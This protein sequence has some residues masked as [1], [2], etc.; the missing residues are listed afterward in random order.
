MT[1]ENSVV[2]KRH[3]T[4]P[5]LGRALCCCELNRNGTGT[6]EICFGGPLRLHFLFNVQSNDL[7]NHG[8]DAPTRAQ[9][10]ARVAIT[11]AQKEVQFL[12]IRVILPVQLCLNTSLHAWLGDFSMT[13]FGGATLGVEARQLRPPVGKKRPKT[14]RCLACGRLSRTLPG[15]RYPRSRSRVRLGTLLLRL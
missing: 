2:F 1:S 14:I 7:G 6:V 10:V 15:N 4:S 12:N 5:K 13:P 3:F 8:S 11:Q 9:T